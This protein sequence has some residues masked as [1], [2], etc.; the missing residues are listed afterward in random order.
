MFI[1]KGHPVHVICNPGHIQYGLMAPMVWK[2][3]PGEALWLYKHPKSMSG[4]LTSRLKRSLNQIMKLMDPLE[5][6]MNNIHLQQFFDNV[7]LNKDCQAYNNA[8]KNSKSNISH[9]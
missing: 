1:S 2:F 6:T 4:S 9:I 7:K 5:L 3:L 8:Q